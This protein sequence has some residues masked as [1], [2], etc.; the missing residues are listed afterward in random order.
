MASKTPATCLRER[1]VC[2]ARVLKTSP[3]V[4]GLLDAESFGGLKAGAFLFAAR[5]AVFFAMFQLQ[6]FRVWNREWRAFYRPSLPASSRVGVFR[7]IFSDFFGISSRRWAWSGRAGRRRVEFEQQ[8]RVVGKPLGERSLAGS[9]GGDPVSERRGDE[10]V[11][12]SEAITPRADPGVAGLLRGECFGVVIGESPGVVES[13]SGEFAEAC[14][15]GVGSV[16]SVDARAPGVEISEDDGGGVA[17]GVGEVEEELPTVGGGLGAFELW[18]VDGGEGE[19]EVWDVGEE[20][21]SLEGWWRGGGGDVE[22]REP[23]GE[24]QSVGAGRGVGG[25]GVLES[26]VGERGGDLAADGG[27]ELGEGDDVGP[28][29]EECEGDLGHSPRASAVEDVPEE[30]AGHVV[31]GGGRGAGARVWT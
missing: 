28:E 15:G 16:W 14:G 12:E 10:G 11:V 24:E 19:G 29:G 6:Y 20:P 2:A 17:S 22:E 4:R 18:E 9:T 8:G 3:L 21:A 7:A 27:S 1:P 31:A 30:D 25:A 23:G 5:F 13:P 26:V